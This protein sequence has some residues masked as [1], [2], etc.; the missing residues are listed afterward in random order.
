M[1]EKI[2]ILLFAIIAN[3]F[4]TIAKDIEP[5][6]LKISREGKVVM[7]SFSAYIPEKAV[8]TDR[9]LLITPQLYNNDGSVSLELFTVTGKQMEKRNKQ[10]KLLDKDATA[11]LYANSSNGSTM[12]YVSSIPYNAWMNNSLSL[13]L[14]VTEEGCCDIKDLGTIASQHPV[15][16]S[17]PYELFLPK[18]VVVESSKVAEMADKYPF[19]RLID[20]DSTGDR[21]TSV[22]FKVSNSNLDISFSS[23]AENIKKIMDGI[24]LVNSDERTRL[25]KITIAGFASPEGNRQHNMQLSENRA[26]ALSQYLQQEMNIPEKAFEIQPGGED[27]AGL[28]ELVKKSDMQYKDEIIDIITNSPVEKR[29][30]QLKQTRG[31]RPYQSMYD[32]M[33]PQLRDACYV[34]VWYSEKKDEVA[35]I[36][37]NA[38]EQITASHYDA[39]LNNLL[40]VKHDSRSWN[41]I[42]TCYILK[43]DYPAARIWLKKAMEAGDK[44]AGMNF[45][46]IN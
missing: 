46:L 36:I 42:G 26:K 35:E 19:L 39:A 14:Q 23:N 10:R 43:D 11:S 22:R 28:L 31:G 15:N 9:R 7:L 5:R 27:W 16:F 25:E 1:K 12:L 44:E 24:R 8:R 17:L 20:K 40:A 4:P 33:Y 21:G 38:I 29:N 3:T 41:A 34:N 45:D 32:V 13:R 30:E 37:N 6:D 2:I 18:E